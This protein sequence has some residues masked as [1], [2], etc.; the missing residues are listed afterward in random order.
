MCNIEN[1]TISLAMRMYECTGTIARISP[2]FSCNL[3]QKC[4]TCANVTNDIGEQMPTKSTTLFNHIRIPNVR[5]FSLSLFLGSFSTVFS[6]PALKQFSY[7]VRCMRAPFTA[8]CTECKI[9]S[10]SIHFTKELVQ[11]CSNILSL[12]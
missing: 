12:C 9:H 3:Q 8:A 10:A 11:K 6:V 2:D 7:F 4:R 5:L 1:H